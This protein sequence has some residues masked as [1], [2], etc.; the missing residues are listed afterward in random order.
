MYHPPGTDDNSSNI[1]YS[2]PYAPVVESKFL[3]YCIIVAGDINRLNITPIKKHFR[4]EQKLIV[5][6]PTRE[7]VILDLVLTML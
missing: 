5:K 3:T 2:I 1:I 7:D 4:L 6:S